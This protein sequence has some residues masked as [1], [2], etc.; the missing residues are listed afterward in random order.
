MNDSFGW[1]AQAGVDVD[2][3]RKVFLNLDV[4]YIDIDTT[5]RL[6]TTAVG[7]QQVKLHLDPFV[8]GVG[9][10]FRL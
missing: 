3:T 5:A 2:L 9:L 7:T 6:Q 4:K 1:A 10:G 8:V